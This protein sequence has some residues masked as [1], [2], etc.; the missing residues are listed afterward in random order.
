MPS[1]SYEIDVT[2][3]IPSKFIR[4]REDLG[5]PAKSLTVVR[6]PAGVTLYVDRNPYPANEGDVYDFE[7]R[8]TFEIRTTGTSSTTLVLYADT[9]G[10]FWIRL[11]LTKIA[12]YRSTLSDV[13]N[14]EIVYALTD[15]K[16]RLLEGKPD[17]IIAGTNTTIGTTASPLVATPTLIKKGVTVK[18]RAIGTGGTYIALGNSTVQPFRL[19]AVGDAF[20]I[21]FIDDLS[22]VYVVSDAASGN[23][24]EYFGG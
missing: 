14:T 19:T 23:V 8:D 20:D 13:Q 1:K 6:V 11:A 5:A 3:A 2:S 16:G 9:K 12:Q 22:K 17:T 15:A 4:V 7:G 10:T 24:L 21:D 18:V